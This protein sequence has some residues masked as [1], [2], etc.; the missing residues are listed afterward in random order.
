M[1]AYQDFQCDQ[2]ADFAQNVLITNA[3]GSA[4]NVAPYIFSA[5]IKTSYFSA[6]VVDTLTVTAIDAPNGN[7][8]ISYAGANSSN[9]PAGHYVYDVRAA[10]TGSGVQRLLQGIFFLVPGVTAITPAS[11]NVAG[12]NWVPYV[13]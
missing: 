13:P 12:N 5:N 10:N 3:D 7:V 1:A 4:T 2:G 8:Q 11:T 9:I 6:N